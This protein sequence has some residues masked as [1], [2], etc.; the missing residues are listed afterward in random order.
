MKR[1]LTGIALGIGL[2]F[3]APAVAQPA[4]T[5]AETSDLQLVERAY[6][7]FSQGGYAAIQPLLP[8]LRA[9][10]DAAPASQPSVE[11]GDDYIIVRADSQSQ[12]ILLMALA[13]AAAPDD[14][15]DRPVVTAPSIYPH[16]ALLLA[17]DAV[18][19]GRY[20]EALGYTGRGLAIQ[21]DSPPLILE[22]SIALLA[23][24][25]DAE[26]LEMIDT[27]LASGSI[28]LMEFEAPLLRRRGATLMELGR[29]GEARTAYEQSLE[30]EPDHPG[31]LHQLR[32]IE[33]AEAGEDIGDFEVVTAAEA[34]GA[35]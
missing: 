34:A 20:A 3:G 33:S 10:L 28:L 16:I 18:E 21:P 11:I 7:A 9:A 6:A 27:A 29:L 25:R 35:D 13:S 1:L 14:G 23:L 22:H 19:H 24:D 5:A 2:M 26:A 31:A 32:I 4:M 30:V 15:R 8:E 17:S 12:A